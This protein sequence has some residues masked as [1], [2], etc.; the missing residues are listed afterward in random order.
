MS[1]ESIPVIFGISAQSMANAKAAIDPNLTPPAD[2]KK[3]IGKDGK[4]Y[5]RWTAAGT[6]DQIWHE[7]TKGSEK[8][9]KLGVF[10][11]GIRFRPG[12][13]NQNKLCFFRLMVHP[14]IAEGKQV[15]AEVKH[16]YQNMT[17]RSLASLASLLDVTGFLP[18]EG[19]LDSKAIN[20]LFPKKGG[21]SPL[22]E[23]LVVVKI[24]QQPNEGGS[25]DKQEVAELFL[26]PKQAQVE[27]A[28][29]P[30]DKDKK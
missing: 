16:S 22:L 27:A 14:A 24:C 20:L 11:V 19:G 25:R 29:E 12:E 18:K 7:T 15:S 21:K 13:A 30:W 4:L 28:K 2:A 6:V 10:V 3:D 26:P 8:K 9:P 5:S 17:E 1:E 23:K